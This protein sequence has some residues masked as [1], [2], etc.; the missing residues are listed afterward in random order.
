VN[1]GRGAWPPLGTWDYKI[2]IRKPKDR[3]HNTENHGKYVCCPIVVC[4]PID[5]DH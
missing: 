4:L 3:E 1:A 5:F 2:I